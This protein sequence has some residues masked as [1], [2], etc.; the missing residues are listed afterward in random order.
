M[1]L[2]PTN[3]YLYRACLCLVALVWAR[4]SPAQVSI[5]TPTPDQT[6]IL[7]LSSTNQGFL[8]PRLS[9]TQ[10]DAISTPAVGL[11]IYNTTK[12]GLELYHG[13]VAE[14]NC[15]SGYSYFSVTVG[16]MYGMMSSGWSNDYRGMAQSFTS[17]GGLVHSISIDVAAVEDSSKSNVYEMVLFAGQPSCGQ[18]GGS[19]CSL[20]DFGTPLH[21]ELFQV[22]A[23]VCEVQF[24]KPIGLAAGSI[25]TFAILPTA[26]Q[27]AFNWRGYT[28]GYSSGSSNGINGNISG[29]SDDFKFKVTY[30]EGW[31]LVP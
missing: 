16:S 27:Q 26:K 30:R 6:A 7:D 22:R 15:L 31:R 5:G 23:G 2:D 20:S 1:I 28:T 19:T 25:Y 17:S 18:S 24:S 14:I 12:N 21:S 29:I 10:R 9:T 3:N 11:M 13:S 8:L 4:T